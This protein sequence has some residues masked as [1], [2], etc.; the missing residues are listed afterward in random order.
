MARAVGLDR[1]LG[2]L[3]GM[4][5]GDAMGMPVAGM[6]AGGF[7]PVTGY[8]AKLFA[9]GAEIGAGEFTDESEVALCIVES[10]TVN[11]GVIDVENIA[12]RMRI[13]ARGESK[14]WMDPTTLSALEASE[15]TLADTVPLTD[16]GPTASDVAARGIP[17]GLLHAVGPFE[18]DQLHSD[19]EAVVRIT[20]G[21]PAA[22]ASATAVAFAVQFAARNPDRRASIS[23]ETARFLGTGGLAEALQSPSEMDPASLDGVIVSAFRIAS[24]PEPVEAAILNAVN[25]GGAA[26]TRG[27][28]VGA[29]RGAAEGIAAIPQGLID[30][31]EGRIYI[32]LAAPW[33]FRAAQRRG[34]LVIEL[35]GEQERS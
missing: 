20:H 1:F 29:I 9:D 4:G 16:D 22:I 7:P 33:F 34:G 13:L 30:R 14:R 24:Q 19:A 23:P 15:E 32:S 10:A 25:E 21:S 27:A 6:A 18:P 11:D 35:T 12:A 26:D 2:S 17:I 5:I 31:L 28:L 8:R 3:F